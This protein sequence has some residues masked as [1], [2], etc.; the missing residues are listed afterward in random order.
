MIENIHSIMRT[1]IVNRKINTISIIIYIITSKFLIFFRNHR[2]KRRWT[3]KLYD[4]K[5]LNE[6]ALNE[7][8]WTKRRRKKTLDEKTWTKICGRKDVG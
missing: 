8:T 3:K 5:T 7:N 6:K 4:D 2:R 1:K